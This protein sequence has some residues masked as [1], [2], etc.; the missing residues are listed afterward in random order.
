M[1]SAPAG[2]SKGT[3]SVVPAKLEGESLD[4]AIQKKVEYYFSQDNLKS[5]SYLVSR[6]NTDMWVDVSVLAQF[7]GLTMMSA[8]VDSIARVMS[9]SDKVIVS[10]D[11]KSIKPNIKLER[12]T[13]ILR[14]IPSDT[15]VEEVRKIFSHLPEGDAPTELKSELGENWFVTFETEDKCV[16]AHVSLVGKTF[17]GKPVRAR[18]K[19]ETILKSFYQPP[20][21]AFYADSQQY[22]YDMYSNGGGYFGNN[23]HMYTQNRYT[24]RAGQQRRNPKKSSRNNKSRSMPHQ[25]ISLGTNH[26]PPLPNKKEI[27]D[28]P[29]KAGYGN[30]PFKRI[31]SSAMLTVLDKI[32]SS[33]TCPK[34]RTQCV[35]TC[36]D[37]TLTSDTRVALT[38]ETSNEIFERIED[39]GQS[40]RTS[41]PATPSMSPFVSPFFTTVPMVF[42]SSDLAL[43]PAHV[44]PEKKTS[45]AYYISC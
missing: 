16:A 38:S 14:D 12:K 8:D 13:L 32:Q 39:P 25:N 21:M 7:K 3:R 37:I 11:G 44:T 45:G 33:F 26:F 28:T 23:G 30:R 27:L 41:G 9:K 43:T 36:Q 10:A 20:P 2:V 19:S 40:P 42:P 29:G 31:E 4:N 1:V 22:G 5:D 15:D 17:Q 6:M 18:V 35:V 34:F 24:N